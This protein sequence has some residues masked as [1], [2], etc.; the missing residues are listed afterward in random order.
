L[1]TLLMCVVLVVRTRTKIRRTPR[2]ASQKSPQF[3]QPASRNWS[4]NVTKTPQC[5]WKFFSETRSFL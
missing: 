4:P 3:Y 1:S 2:T 5:D